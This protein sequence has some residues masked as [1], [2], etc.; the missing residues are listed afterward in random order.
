MYSEREDSKT[1]DNAGRI[2]PRHDSYSELEIMEHNDPHSPA[3][4]AH[5]AGVN[6]RAQIVETQV[7]EQTFQFPI[8]TEE[9]IRIHTE[10]RPARLIYTVRCLGCDRVYPL[11][12]EFIDSALSVLQEWNCPNAEKHDD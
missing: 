12:M 3:A 9:G 7:C 2:A 8:E 5:K 1:L 10:V 11:D 4:L 6:H